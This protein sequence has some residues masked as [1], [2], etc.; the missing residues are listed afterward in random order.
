MKQGIAQRPAR[1]RLR[2]SPDRGQRTRSAED[3]VSSLGCHY[4]NLAAAEL[5]VSV[6]AW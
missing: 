2:K 3:D 5:G 6:G 1:W 4:L